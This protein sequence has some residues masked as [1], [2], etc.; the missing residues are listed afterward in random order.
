ML[1]PWCY[2]SYQSYQGLRGSAL[3]ATRPTGAIYLGTQPMCSSAPQHVVGPVT[4]EVWIDHPKVMAVLHAGL[5]SPR[6]TNPSGRLPYTITK[7]HADYP[8]DI[9]YTS[10]QPARLIP[11]ITWFDLK[12]ATGAPAANSV[13]ASGKPA[14]SPAC[15]SPPPLPQHPP[16]PPRPHPGTRRCYARGAAESGS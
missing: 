8:A 10:N 12:H 16:P 4:V 3:N 7:E 13:A 14:S 5:P 15:V 9:L 2:H 6:A 1:S 11:Q